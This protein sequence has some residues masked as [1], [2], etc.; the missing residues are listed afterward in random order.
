MIDT[1]L[2]VALLVV[3]RSPQPASGAVACAQADHATPYQLQSRE[4]RTILQRP[5]PSLA[6]PYISL[7]LLSVS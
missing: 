3:L 6:H 2:L 5:G 1:V 4:S 7:A